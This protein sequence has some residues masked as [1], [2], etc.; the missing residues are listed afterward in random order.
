MSCVTTNKRIFSRLKG[1]YYE[2]QPGDCI[3][4]N[5]ANSTVGQLIIQLCRLLQLRCVAVVREREQA[6]GGVAQCADRLKSLGATHVLLDKGSLKVC[7]NSQQRVGQPCGCACAALQHCSWEDGSHDSLSNSRNGGSAMVTVS[8]VVQAACVFRA[9]SNV[10]GYLYLLICQL[11]T[12][13][14]ACGI[15][16]WCYYTLMTQ[17]SS[18]SLR[19][20]KPALH[21]IL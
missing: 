18:T 9:C 6:T 14:A 17:T 10:S 12:A 8:S 3:I 1:C 20:C 4:L 15:M 19:E 21:P 7:S 13:A 2:L 11:L 5:A 16:F